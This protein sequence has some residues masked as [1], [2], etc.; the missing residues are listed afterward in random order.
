MTCGVNERI[1]DG[2]LLAPGH[3]VGA[4]VAQGERGSS[5]YQEGVIVGYILDELWHVGVKWDSGER[6]L[7]LVL[8]GD[9]LTFLDAEPA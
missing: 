2:M 6:E 4:R 9:E 7:V 3:D 8:N 5:N 1:V